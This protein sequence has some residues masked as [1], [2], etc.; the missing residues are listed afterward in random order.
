LNKDAISARLNLSKY[1]L[2]RNNEIID[3]GAILEEI[4]S[5]FANAYVPYNIQ[6]EILTEAAEIGVM[7]ARAEA[8][9]ADEV[10][11]VYNTGKVSDKYRAPKGKGQVKKTIKPG[12]LKSGIRI[13][14]HGKFKK[15]HYAVFYGPRY[16][17]VAY[18][19][20]VEFGSKYV[21]RVQPF[22]KPS[23]DKAIMP[24]L[25]LI[26]QRYRQELLKVANEAAAKKQIL[27]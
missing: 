22:M 10:V 19:H 3:I 4:K 16:P 2:R 9:I 23:F 8:P 25:A 7:Y 1:Q 13:F 26:K 21:K 6:K 14:T 5:E 11:K 18:A 24:M 15:I 17:M 27:K 20:I 12:N